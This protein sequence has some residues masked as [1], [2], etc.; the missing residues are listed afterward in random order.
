MAARGATIVAVDRDQAALATLVR[1]IPGCISVLADVTEEEAVKN[2]AA[3]AVGVNGRIDI[4]FNNAGIEGHFHPIHEYPT[5]AFH[6]IVNINLIGAF[7]GYKHVVPHMLAAGKGSIIVTSSV[8]GL[9]G[10]PHICAYTATKHA[11]LGLMRSVAAECGAAGV[12]SNAVN[13]G[14]IESR[15]MADVE[16]GMGQGLPEGAIRAVMTQMV[17]MRRYGTPSEVAELV[18]FLGSEAASFVNGAVMA[19]DG[20]FTAV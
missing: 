10:T 8:G 1:D 20:G 2:Y 6:K 19:V 13:P 5:D 18:A 15:M 14:P 7:L 11:V 12:R 4:F 9:I 16:K 3:R 17:P